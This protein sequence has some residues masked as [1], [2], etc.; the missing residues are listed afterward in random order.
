MSR[1]KH[2]LSGTVIA[3]DWYNNEL[4]ALT[5]GV[6]GRL[7]WIPADHVAVGL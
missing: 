6:N 4:Y 1:S 2:Y 3:L 7:G 5:V